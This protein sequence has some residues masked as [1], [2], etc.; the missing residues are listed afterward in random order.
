MGFGALV[1]AGTQSFELS[2]CLVPAQGLDAI[3]SLLSWSRILGW[4]QLHGTSFRGR[5]APGCATTLLAVEI[6]E[7]KANLLEAY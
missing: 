6:K 5:K 7:F 4:V 2:R 1:A 3:S